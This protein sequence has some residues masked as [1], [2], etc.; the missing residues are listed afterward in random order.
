MPITTTTPFELFPKRWPWPKLSR[1]L[2]TWLLPKTRSSWSRLITPT[3]SQSMGTRKGATLSWVLLEPPTWIICP[4]RRYCTPM[5][6]IIVLK[7]GNGEI[8]LTPILVCFIKISSKICPVLPEPV[9]LFSF[10]CVINFL[11]DP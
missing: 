8:S 9:M 3:C 5:D 11:N 4:I 6:L 10:K 2:S 7:M 1:L